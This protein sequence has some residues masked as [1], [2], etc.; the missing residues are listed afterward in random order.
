MS[1]Q[2]DW[3]L[4]GGGL[5][6]G[7][8]LLTLLHDRP[9][10]SVTLVERGPC[11]G[12]N[13][14]WSLH[15]LDVSAT[16]RERLTPAFCG[17]WDRHEVRFPDRHR[18][19][20]L[21]YASLTG[22]GLHGL[23]TGLNRPNVRLLTGVEVTAV[24]PGSATL[25]DGRV[26]RGRR[27]LDARGPRPIVDTRC[28]YQKFVGLEVELTAD[29]PTPFPTLMDAGVEQLDG[30]RFVY[31]LP[32]TPRR[33][34]VEDTYYSDGP[35]LDVPA[36][37]HRVRDYLREHGHAKC[38]VVREETG[39]LPIPWHR[40]GEGDRNDDG[41][42]RGGYAGGWFHPATGYSFPAAAALAETLVADGDLAALRRRHRTQTRFARLL[43][44]LLFRASPPPRRWEV[45]SRFYGLPE[46][47]IARFYA[48]D[49]TRR[50]RLW[51]FLGR[52]PRGVS[53]GYL[54]RRLCGR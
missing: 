1:E 54:L 17:V 51:T 31:T 12:G 27:V 29:W 33:V 19:L 32:F 6:N 28:G 16:M 36:V 23:L 35:E 40:V 7:L 3:L 2:S 37:R 24:T 50:D 43:N 30:Y 22:Q 9:G 20:P 10:E 38:V 53:V 45:L 15:E 41:V 39:V 42:Q 14:T 25:A 26:L 8:I 52:P 18:V 13:H 21:S 34:L 5:Q 46:G 44:W 49:T 11:L 48:L 4:I 47:L